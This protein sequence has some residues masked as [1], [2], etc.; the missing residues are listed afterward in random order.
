MILEHDD[1]IFTGTSIQYLLVYVLGDLKLAFIANQLSFFTFL[2]Y[3]CQNF[4][5]S[6]YQKLA[7]AS[8]YV[9]SN[10]PKYELVVP[11]TQLHVSDLH[12][13]FSPLI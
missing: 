10:G 5:N 7:A 8:F 13:L 1:V 12:S 11:H 4:K 3:F 6:S 2:L 9:T